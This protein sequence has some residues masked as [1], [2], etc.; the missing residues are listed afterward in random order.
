ME[1]CLEVCLG[2]GTAS[3]IIRG[4]RASRSANS[5]IGYPVCLLMKCRIGLPQQCR[6]PSQR[7]LCPQSVDRIH[8]AA[9]EREERVVSWNRA[10]NFN[11]CSGHRGSRGFYS[12]NRVVLDDGFGQS[13]GKRHAYN[14]SQRATIRHP[15]YDQRKWCTE[16]RTVVGSVSSHAVPSRSLREGIRMGENA[17]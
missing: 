10:H 12:D 8:K 6:C 14:T 7:T 11:S 3:R 2:G 15:G 4:D 13:L 5:S 17:G 1:L 16:T 9:S